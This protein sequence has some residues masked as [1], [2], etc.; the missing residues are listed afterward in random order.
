M[1]WHAELLHIEF[2]PFLE[3]FSE[4]AKDVASLRLGEFAEA[5]A[6]LYLLKEILRW[7]VEDE[8]QVRPFIALRQR[9]PLLGHAPKTFVDGQPDI[10][11]MLGMPALDHTFPFLLVHKLP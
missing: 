9:F 1:R 6:E 4:P 11:I 3:L 5:G 8:G 2:I 7:E 10:L